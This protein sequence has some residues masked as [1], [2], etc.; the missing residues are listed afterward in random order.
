M[1][2]HSSDLSHWKHTHR[3][4]AD[5]PFGKRR[6]YIVTILTFI[7]MVAEITAGQFFHSMALFADGWHMGT[8]VVALGIT[9][10][11]YFY[12]ERH[13][14]DSRFSFGTGKVGFLGGYTSAVLLCLVAAFMMFECVSRLVHPVRIFFNEALIVACIGLTFNLFSA[15]MLGGDHSHSHNHH[16][17]DHHQDHDDDHNHDHG[18]KHDLNL[19]AAYLHV[20]ADAFTSLLAII[21]LSFGRFFG[22]GWL[23]PVIGIVGS[24]VVAQWAIGLMRSTSKVLLDCEMDAGVVAEIHEA[25]EADR[26]T[27]VSDLHL[28]RVGNNEYAV[29][30]T[31]VSDKPQSPQYYKD[32]IRIHEELVHI[33]VEVNLCPKHASA[34]SVMA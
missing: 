28:V 30:L 34:H 20:L 22:W 32:L 19:R 26:D 27:K 6:T 12:T 3:F 9:G 29:V 7:M 4:V 11:A 17:H 33:S 14:S 25:I 21:A 1:N 24:L 16:G 23:D 10:F 2:M 31:V 5:N 8:H 18:A 13:H 15:W